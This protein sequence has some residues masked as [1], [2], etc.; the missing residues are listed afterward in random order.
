LAR[1][2]HAEKLGLPILARFVDYVVAGNFILKI[3]LNIINNLGV[4]P[5]VMGIGPAVAIP[6]LLSRNGLT[7]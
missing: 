2:S 5:N 3:I 1:R 7:P 4:P 6:K